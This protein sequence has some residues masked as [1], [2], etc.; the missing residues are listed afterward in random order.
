MRKEN[1]KVIGIDVDLTVVNPVPSWLE[2]YKSKTGHDLND[3]ITDQESNLETLM[4]RHH[5]P[6]SFW[7]D[8]NLYD[9]LEPI[10]NSV[11]SIT[12][13]YD[14]GYKIVFISSCFPEHH[15]SKKLF[16]KRNFNFPHGFINS[17][18]KGY[19]RPDIFID[20]YKKYLRL[21]REGNPDCDCIQIQS[22]INSES[23]D[24]EFPY[25][26]WDGIVKRILGIKDN[27]KTLNSEIACEL[28]GLIENGYRLKDFYSEK[29]FDFIVDDLTDVMWETFA[30]QVRYYIER[31]EK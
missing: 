3:E 12:K 19:V 20:D 4:H 7:R 8:P 13:L 26:T 30:E 27:M 16:L 9:E 6:L 24:G 14:A 15:N 22:P 29:D 31:G 1:G 2:W 28:K 21:V 5:D 10:E 18:D 17:G 23:I 25:L 11:E